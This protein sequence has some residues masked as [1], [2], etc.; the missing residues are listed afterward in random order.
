MERGRGSA[1]QGMC[2][3][4]IERFSVVTVIESDASGD[5]ATTLQARIL[6]VIQQQL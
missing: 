4:T 5:A 2:T 1:K 3:S 6:Q